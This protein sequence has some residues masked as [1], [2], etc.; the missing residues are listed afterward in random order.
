M[1]DARGSQK[2]TFGIV[3]QD[4]VHFVFE[5]RYLIDTK[6]GWPESPRDPSV[7]PFLPPQ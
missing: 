5:T 7:Y 6:T 4:P 2:L 1:Y 3:A